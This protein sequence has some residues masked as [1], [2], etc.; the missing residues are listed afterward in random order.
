MEPHSILSIKAP[1]PFTHTRALIWKLGLYNTGH[2]STKQLDNAQGH[3]L[4]VLQSLGW[5]PRPAICTEFRLYRGV[6]F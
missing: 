4:K 2:F 6:N 3:F 1:Y 5:K